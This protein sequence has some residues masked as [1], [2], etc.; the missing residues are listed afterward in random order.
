ME[1]LKI[2]MDSYKNMFSLPKA[3]MQDNVR[4]QELFCMIPASTI[5]NDVVQRFRCFNE[6][7]TIENRISSEDCFPQVL[8]RIVLGF[9]HLIIS[10]NFKRSPPCN[11]LGN[12]T[13]F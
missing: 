2:Q 1:K 9:F 6:H 12:N 11:K 7:R 4:V 8:L 3:S 5:R 13:N 10:V